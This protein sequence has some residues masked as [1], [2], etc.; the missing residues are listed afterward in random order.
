M[1]ARKEGV[2]AALDL[3]ALAFRLIEPAIRFKSIM[4][5][6][7]TVAPGAL[8]AA[9]EGPSGDLTQRIDRPTRSPIV[10]CAS[11]A[12]RIISNLR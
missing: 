1:A 8:I 10:V 6:G 12:C 5:D 2:V 3:A 7:A 4:A 11:T 9:I